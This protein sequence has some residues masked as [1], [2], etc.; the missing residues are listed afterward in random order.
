MEAYAEAK[1]KV[2]S[3]LGEKDLAVV[4]DAD[5]FCRR[6]AGDLEKRRVRVCHVVLEEPSAGP[7]AAFVRDDRLVVRLDGVERVLCTVD[8]LGIKGPHNVLNALVASAMALE[9][10]VDPQ[11]VV[12]GLTT[13]APLEHR[14]EPCGQAGG[15]FF[16]NDS[17]ATNVDA[18]AKALS[19]FEAGRVVV[20]LGGHDKGTELDELREAVVSSCKAAVCYGEAGER[21]ARALEDAQ[22]A[23]S[24]IRAP[25]MAEALDA[26]REVAVSGDTVLLSPACSSFD[27]F[28]SY[29]ERGRIFKELVAQLI[30]DAS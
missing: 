6:I 26:A 25:H 16:V 18:V 23:L 13:F 19:A 30:E 29:T 1:A 12:A 7:S 11:A 22:G 20:L 4:V 2:F 9:V 3:R 14:I 8:A 27:E 10:G 17:K 15:V 5:D 28:K 24:V 21:I